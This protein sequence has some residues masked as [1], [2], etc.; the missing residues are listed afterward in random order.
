MLLVK[1]S[2]DI[3]KLRLFGLHGI[4]IALAD[5]IADNILLKRIQI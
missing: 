3:F 2:M 5:E 1:T 4:D